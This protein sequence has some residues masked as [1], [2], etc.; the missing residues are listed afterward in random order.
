V[1]RYR[2]IAAEKATYPVSLLCRVLRVS[3]ASFYA[4]LH[5]EDDGWGARPVGLTRGIHWPCC[6]E[7]DLSTG[8][9]GCP[10]HPSPTK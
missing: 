1:S 4:W 5:C 3:R 2:F 9:G 8:R 7:S 6:P 10:R